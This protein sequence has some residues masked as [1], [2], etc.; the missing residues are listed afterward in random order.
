MARYQFQAPALPIPTAEYEQGQQ[1]QFSRALRLY[2][3]LL[4][5]YNVA[6]S[7][8]ISVIQGDITTINDQITIINGEIDDLQAQIHPFI[9]ASDSALQYATASNTPTIVNWTSLDSGFGF[10]LNAGN[11]ATALYAGYYKITYSL[12]F[13]NNDNAAHDSIVWLRLN[14]DTPTEDVAGSSTIFTVPARKSATEPAYVCGYSEVVFQM[15]VGDT[16]GLWWGTDQAASSGGATGNYIDYRA[17]QTLPMP[18]PETPSAI[19]SI[20]FVSGLY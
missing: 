12:Q 15:D 17:A 18:Y 1:F 10:A 8:E 7:E 9:A 2:F 5:S 4:D 19:G 14:G 6:T 20:T 3:N 11:T 13:A 16:V